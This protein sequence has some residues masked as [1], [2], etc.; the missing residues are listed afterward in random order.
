MSNDQQHTELNRLLKVVNYLIGLVF[1]LVFA[2]MLTPILVWKGDSIVDFFKSKPTKEKIASSSSIDTVNYWRPK[3]ISA[4]EDKSQKELVEY[5]KELIAHTSRYLGPK[6]S[7]LQLSNGLNCQNCHLEAGTKIWGN[8]YGSVASTYPKFRARSGMEENMYKRINDCF[9]RSLNGLALD[10]LSKEM[11]AIKA[12][13]SYIGADVKKDEKALGSGFKDLAFL[14]RA[15][16]PAHGKEVYIA[17]C[18]SCHMADGQGQLNPEGTEYSFPALWGK[19]SYNDGAGLYRI[20]NFAKY[21]KNN[22]PQGVTYHEPKLSDE[23]AWDVA[24]F[25]NSQPRPHKNT[26]QDWPD[27]AKKPIDHPFGP[28]ADQFT[29][30]QHKFG[31]FKPIQKEQKKREAELKKSKI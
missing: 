30:V 2:V 13:I 20:S 4:I 27:I 14:D 18:Q 3:D 19:H 24:A 29:E 5:G 21:V 17:Q 9:E 31:P 10:S 26:P 16:D 23:E 28:Y 15:A 12:Y 25:V 7:V 1:L 8:N 22:M 11:Q 6:G